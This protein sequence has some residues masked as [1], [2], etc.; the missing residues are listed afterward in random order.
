MYLFKNECNT[1]TH[2]FLIN[3]EVSLQFVV[4]NIKHWDNNFN[5]DSSILNLLYH[6]FLVFFNKLLIFQRN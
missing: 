2:T 5:I 1:Q 3:K 6:I 4:L